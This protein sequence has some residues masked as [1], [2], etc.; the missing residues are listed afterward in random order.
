MV[1]KERINKFMVI[2]Y[3]RKSVL[4]SKRWFTIYLLL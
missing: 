1:D 2:S 4:G 3:V